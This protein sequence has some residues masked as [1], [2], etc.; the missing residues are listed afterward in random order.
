MR[1]LTLLFPVLIPALALGWAGC[2][3]FDGDDEE[4]LPI[5]ERLTV[6]LQRP[7]AVPE[8]V[9]PRAAFLRL[10]SEDDYRC[11][12]YRI[13]TRLSFDGEIL[14]LEVRGVEEPEGGCYTALGPA[15]FST[16]LELGEGA[17]GLYIETDDRTDRY[18]LEI[19]ADAVRL[20]PEETSFTAPEPGEGG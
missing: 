6:G 9:S 19:A 10:R 15:E 14:R 7:D 12:G 2:S 5:P 13:A 17:Y 16:Y 1:R 18:R 11:L 4:L 8:E 3:L 20:I